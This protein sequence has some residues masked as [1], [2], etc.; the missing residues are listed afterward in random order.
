MEFRKRRQVEQ[1]VASTPVDRM[2]PEFFDTIPDLFNQVDFLRIHLIFPKYPVDF[3]IEFRQ[4]QIA[5]KVMDH[6][7]RI[8]LQSVLAEVRI[9]FPEPADAVAFI[10]HGADQDTGILIAE[11][12][13]LNP[14]SILAQIILCQS[15]G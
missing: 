5:G 6:A 10:P 7:V 13:R 4:D 9:E 14:Q 11:F 12:I 15:V 8:F 1:N 2:S 3:D